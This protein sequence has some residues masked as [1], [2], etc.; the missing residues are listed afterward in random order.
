MKCFHVNVA[1]TLACR[2][3]PQQLAYGNEKFM[4]FRTSNV[5]FSVTLIILCKRILTYR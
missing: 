3:P 4:F 1:V 2:I 5:T